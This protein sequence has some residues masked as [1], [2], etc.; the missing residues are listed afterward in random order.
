MKLLTVP[1]PILY[2]IADVVTTFDSKLME[3]VAGMR[4]VLLKGSV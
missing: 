1:D 4:K 3:D 2:Q